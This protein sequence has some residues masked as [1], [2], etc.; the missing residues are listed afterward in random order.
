MEQVVEI[1]KNAAFPGVSCRKCSL[2]FIDAKALRKVK[3]ADAELAFCPQCGAHLA[4]FVE[5]AAKKL[6][7]SA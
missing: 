5:T 2:T 4:V 1:G 6:A 7:K 3:L